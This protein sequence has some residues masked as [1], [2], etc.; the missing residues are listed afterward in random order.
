MKINW[1][2][3]IVIGL[4]IILLVSIFLEGVVLLINYYLGFWVENIH[5]RR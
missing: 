2:K 5:I 3:K 4:L 1:N